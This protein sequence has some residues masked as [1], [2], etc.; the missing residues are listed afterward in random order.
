V[1]CLLGPQF[2][3]CY[4]ILS[5]HDCTVEGMYC[6]LYVILQNACHDADT[7]SEGSCKAIADLDTF[8]GMCVQDGTKVP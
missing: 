1:E 8:Q 2:S 3:A 5:T 7:V 4:Y 6:T